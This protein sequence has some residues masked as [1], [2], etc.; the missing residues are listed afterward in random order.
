MLPVFSLFFP[1]TLAIGAAAIVHFSNNILKFGM[2]YRHIHVQT[3]IRFG[4]PALIAALGGSLLGA[5]C[6]MKI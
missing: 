1:L 4:I 3:L 5:Y 2:L 6:W